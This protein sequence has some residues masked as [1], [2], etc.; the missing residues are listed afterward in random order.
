MLEI[1]PGDILA[2][3]P[4]PE[5][6]ARG[7]AIGEHAAG[8]DARFVHIG[9]WT[10][11]GEIAAYPN[12]VQ[13]G[14]KFPYPCDVLRPDLSPEAIA[15]GLAWLHSKVRTPY[16]W[17]DL[18]WVW[19]VR[20]LGWRRAINWPDGTVICSELGAG[21]LRRCGI[22]PWPQLFACEVMPG[23][24]DGAPGLTNIGSL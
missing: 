14:G 5:L 4:N 9:I 16:A 7:I 12:G 10:P 20:R 3:K 19:F 8:A 6:W 23:D 2:Y 15:N 24:Y 1:K 18:A 13:L 11:D 21:F 22:D 17:W